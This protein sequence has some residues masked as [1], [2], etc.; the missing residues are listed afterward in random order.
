MHC[1]NSI[2]KNIVGYPQVLAAVFEVLRIFYG[3]QRNAK[4]L[5][6]VINLIEWLTTV[7]YQSIFLTTESDF[8]EERHLYRYA[9]KS[10]KTFISMTDRQEFFQL[11][12]HTS[13]IKKNVMQTKNLSIEW[14]LTL[15]FKLQTF[16]KRQNRLLQDVNKL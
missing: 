2:V 11:T 4:Q 10:A 6:Q 1:I 5:V 8:Y 15:G 16:F 3:G 12:T 9:K 13:K 14:L 7:K